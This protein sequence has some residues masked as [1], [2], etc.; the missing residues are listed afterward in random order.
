MVRP[1][2]IGV[3]LP[4]VER[5]VRWSEMA[6]IARTAEAVGFDSVWV[7][8]HLLY[9]DGTR[10]RGPLDAWSILA[11]LAAVTERV[12]IGPLVSCAGFRSP[13]ILARMAHAVD[14]MSGGRLVLGLGCGWNEVE[15]KA[16]GIPFDHRVARFEESFEVI[17]R[18][19]AG[20][21]VTFSGR[22][23]RLE[24]AELLPHPQR[25]VRLMVGSNSPRMLA[26]TLPHVERWNTW[27]DDYG[28]TPTGFA[29]L[30]ATISEAAERAGRTPSDL[31][32]SACVLV[33][34]D[35]E[36][37]ERVVPEGIVPLG[38]SAGE[39]A[40][41]LRALAA[42]GADEAI[43]VVT[44]INASSVERLGEVLALLDGR[45]TAAGV[46]H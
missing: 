18:L 6:D 5:E 17:R 46:R 43:L 31:R 34:L 11:G 15:F 30:N 25:A 10:V 33:A 13:G 22:Y 2:R 14:D 20:E 16:F 1:L 28:N 8:D 36:G 35:P 24:E 44:P 9:R 27:W 7:G 21:R 12:E 3:Q 23:A 37:S 41:G 45:D 38:G 40:E 29:R 4:E 26:T 32:R 39:I 19:L 42:A